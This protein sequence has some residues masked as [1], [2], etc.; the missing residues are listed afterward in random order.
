MPGSILIRGMSGLGDNIH[1]RAIVRAFLAQGE[2]IWIETPWPVVYADLPS[3]RCMRRAEHLR[4]Q[5]KNAVRED[6]N[7]WRGQLP[8]NTRRMQI[9]YAPEIVR[10]EGGCVL[11]A[12]AA[13]VGMLNARLDFRIPVPEEWREVASALVRREVRGRPILFLRPLMDRSE[14]GG[15]PARNPDHEAYAKLLAS[16]RDRFCVISVADLEDGREWLVGPDLEP[17]IAFHGGELNFETMAGLMSI[18]ALVFTTPGFAVPL[19]QAVETPV[20]CVFGGYEFNTSFIRGAK[21]TPTL[22]LGPGCGCFRH[23]HACDKRFD[24]DEAVAK[25]KGFL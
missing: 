3:V 15:C 14:W 19:A 10:R 12:M 16:I 11:S 23:D 4:T 21:F 8:N 6:E 18:S 20:A 5:K 7:F 24:V 9:T 1:Q 25:L 22:A 17:D 2:K 13:S